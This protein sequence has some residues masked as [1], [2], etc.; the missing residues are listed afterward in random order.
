[1]PSFE[2]FFSHSNKYKGGEMM[3]VKSLI[4]NGLSI[5]NTDQ[6]EGIY[7]SITLSEINSDILKILFLIGARDN[8]R[9]VGEI[10]VENEV[11]EE[12]GLR[13]I[14]FLNLCIALVDS[15]GLICEHGKIE[16]YPVISYIIYDN[17]DG[18]ITIVSP[19]LNV[20]LNHMLTVIEDVFLDDIIQETEKLLHNGN[21]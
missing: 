20:L 15:I 7:T 11:A 5:N 17:P 10:I 18:K 8:L 3:L 4:C 14:D 1:M 16:S 12:Y 21:I 13:T 19:Y 6:R 9:N 2:A